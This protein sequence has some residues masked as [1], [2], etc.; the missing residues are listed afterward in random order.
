MEDK[1]LID[2]IK[3]HNPSRQRYYSMILGFVAGVIVTSLFVVF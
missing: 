3:D 1:N 2:K